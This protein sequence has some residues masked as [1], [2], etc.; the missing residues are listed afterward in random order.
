MSGQAMR[1]D[2]HG[3]GRL[4]CAA[5][6]GRLL[7]AV[8]VCH[9][10]A[11]GI[12]AF[13]SGAGAQISPGPLSSA[14]ASLDGPLNCSKC[15][16]GGK[17]S[18]TG[19]CVACHR[20][21]AWLTEQ[22]RGFHGRAGRAD[23]ATCHPDHAGKDFALVKWPDGSA[24]R[25]DHARTGWALEDKHAHLAC[26]KCH[27]DKLRTSPAA[28]L[29]PKRTTPGWV[30]LETNCAS[31]HEDVHKA[32]LGRTC[33]SCHTAAGW[34]PAPKFD[35]AQS[36][37]PLT[38]KHADVACEKCHTTA[39][40]RAGGAKPAV[41]LFKPL[42]HGDCATCHRDPHAGRLRGACS[43]C[44][45]TTSFSSVEGRTFSHDRTRYALRGR[46]ASV[47]CVGCHTGYPA[48]IDQPQFA[49]C[50]G[51]HADPH[52]GQATL[53]GAAVDCA[54]CH[55]VAGYTPSTF[56]VAQHA[57]TA[58]PLE[59]RHATASCAGCH[60]RAGAR[61]T[62]EV[63]MR[64]AAAR[65]ESCHADQHGGQLAGLS[66]GG[67]CATCH[68]PSGWKPSTF[69][70][71]DHAALRVPLTGRHA[72]ID[73]ASCHSA[74]RRGLPAFPATRTLGNARVALHLD[75]TTCDACHRDP[76]A[77]R[78]AAAATASQS[79]ASCHD[80]RTFRPST[81]DAEAHSRFA[82]ALEGAH[83]AAPCIA[84]HT[85]MKSA[86]LGAS[87][88]LAPAPAKPVSYAIPGA[89]C[90]GCH[91]TPHGTQFAARPD[92]GACQSCHDLN[93]WSPASR[94]V[95]EANSGFVLG[96]AHARVPCARCHVTSAGAAAGGAARTWH[97]VP[98]T[99]ESCHRNGPPST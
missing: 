84:C 98:R 33:E 34:S 16:G 24:Q 13:V 6:A 88:K 50:A 68:T 19:R 14:H 22:K 40:R 21:I 56:T 85:T 10:F 2:A 81:I 9:M 51:C 54:A 29:A 7:R 5:R 70:A 15:H 60:S 27:T 38:G 82:F 71:R 4:A 86:T 11:A 69:G 65:C 46:H 53:R 61:G 35:H 95:H 73:C 49:T 23:C 58:Y 36:Q 20:E 66:A 87:L 18:M 26:E 52:R 47:S 64:P 37:Y 31:C 44:H 83:R 62:R 59:G 77:G 99:C 72:A 42:A 30:G 8:L 41:A 90:A 75:E 78:Y 48:R 76:H 89:S 57:Q 80:T 67:A 39:E 3:V 96:A 91:G 93:G 25:F 97:G 55:T 32:T 1:H 74:S 12:P 94:F 28:T 79:C 17:E 63:V 45:V 43:S 92:S